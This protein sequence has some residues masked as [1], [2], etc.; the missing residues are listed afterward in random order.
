MVSDPDVTVRA[1][2]KAL[3][4]VTPVPAVL[5]NVT[6]GLVPAPILIAPPLVL[7]LKLELSGRLNARLLVELPALKV[8]AVDVGLSIFM[9]APEPRLTVGVLM[10]KA[11]T[12]F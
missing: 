8:A 5:V 11:P 1:P 2:P 6:D 3:K 9:V 4:A 12:T 7:T 10:V